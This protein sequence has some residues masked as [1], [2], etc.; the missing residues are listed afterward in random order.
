MK[1]EVH[2]FM[3]GA[4]GML[5]TVF[6]VQP[7]SKADRL[8]QAEKPVELLKQILEFITVDG[9]C[10]LDQFAGSGPLGEAALSMNRN[11]ILIEKDHDTF[12]MMEQRLKNFA[13]KLSVAQPVIA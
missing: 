4:N 2:H 11:S 10:V 3:S 6:D 5:P 8:H 13:L 12:S 1:K 7:P 9:K